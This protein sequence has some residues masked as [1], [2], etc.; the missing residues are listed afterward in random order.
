M[1]SPKLTGSNI[2]ADLNLA[3]LV[4][5]IWEKKFLFAASVILCVG[6]AYIYGKVVPPIYAVKTTLL[7]DSSGNSRKLGDSKYVEGGVGL[8]DME[9]NLSNE[10]GIL[11]SYSLMEK[12]VK[13]LDFQVSYYTGKWYKEREAYGYFPF[14]VEL[15]DSSAQM[16]GARFYVELLSDQRYRLSV[17]AKEFDVSNPATGTTRTVERN[18]EFSDVFFF[19]KEV[20]HD[21]FHFII[22]KPDYKVV[23]E[24][25]EGQE[26]S[27][28]IHSIS[29]LAKAYASKLDVS[30]VDIK[31]SIL[32]LTSQGQI[33]KKEIDF[34]TKLTDHYIKSKLDERDEI[35]L[36]KETFIREQL[37]G[38][39]D[40]LAKAELRLE[41]FRSRAQ[42]V[43]L[44]QTATNALNQVQDL[45]STK[46]QLELKV[47]YYNSLL[48]YLSDTSSID[49]IIAPSVAGIDDPLLNENLLELKR[50]YSERSRLKYFKGEKSYD[51]EIIEQQIKATTRSLRENLKNLINSSMLGLNNLDNQILS[52]EGTISQLPS[53]EK[54]LLNYQRKSNLYENLFNY[55][56]QELAKTGIARAEDIPDTKVLDTP[57]MVG[58]GPVEPQKGMLMILGFLIG[59]ILPLG[60]VII[61]HSMDEKVQDISQLEASSKIPVAASIAHDY[62]EVK[63][64]L[65]NDVQLEWQVQE[66]F[67][68]LVAKIQFLITDPKKNVIGLTSTVPDEGKTFCALNLGINF[69]R[70]G[71]KTLLIDSDFRVPSQMKEDGAL[72]KYG[73]SDYLKGEDITV[74][75]IIHV[76]E[77]TPNLHYIPTRIEQNF[78]PQELLTSPRLEPLI[79]GLKDSYDY[80][81]VDSPAVGL[82]S[83]FLLVSKLLDIQLF[84]IRRKVSKLS[85]LHGL[86]KLIKKG[87]M[88]NTFLI[89]NDAIGKSFKYGYGDYSYGYG[90]GYGYGESKGK[91]KRRRKNKVSENGYKNGVQNGQADKKEK[92]PGNDI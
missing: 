24:D 57:R 78:N 56:S 35:A 2:Y 33:P 25:F 44:T 37:A 60:L 79:L 30:Q 72:K 67:R 66:S 52:Y 36:S 40:S 50:L 64:T 89:F 41:A 6:I 87:K 91:N 81:I 82:V 90:Y 61:Q 22:K 65:T 8:I 47:K 18:F 80:I 49:K 29:G 39:T 71:K 92:A 26:L 69:A 75:D 46:A 63:P 48:Q 3:G 77:F 31:A 34:L 54:Q 88:K 59:L 12:T 58:D 45:Q 11:K 23:P 53:N 68:D 84:V 5:K 14:E 10:M 42:A 21:Y 38:V 28:Q 70:G 17:A 15:I 7:I 13:D 51:L 1:E 76:N 73:L 20:A 55:L 86:E 9:K 19:G 85:F 27:F 83:D 16:F 4:K 43:N 32:K 74:D 62:S